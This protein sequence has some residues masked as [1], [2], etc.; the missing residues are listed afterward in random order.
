MSKKHSTLYIYK[1]NE[2][3]EKKNTDE[4]KKTKVLFFLNDLNG[5]IG[6]SK[7]LTRLE[8]RLNYISKKPIE[9]KI[10]I[11]PEKLRK[12]YL[13]QIILTTMPTLGKYLVV[14]ELPY[15]FDNKLPI[16]PI[17]LRK[18]IFGKCYNTPII[19]LPPKLEILIFGDA[20][21][22]TVSYFPSTLRILKYG[23]Y[24]NLN[25]PDN[26]P[27]TV[28]KI[29]FG[30]SFNRPIT[31]FPKMLKTI[32]FGEQFNNN[33][34]VDFPETIEK[35]IFGKTLNKKINNLDKLQNLKKIKFN[36]FIKICSPLPSKLKYIANLHITENS[37][38][39]KQS[40]TYLTYLDI[41]IENNYIGNF[42]ENLIYLRLKLLKY[43]KNILPILPPKLISLHINNYNNT[44]PELEKHQRL[45][46]LV[47]ENLQHPLQKLPYS[48]KKLYLLNISIYIFKDS[49]N[50]NKQKKNIFSNDENVKLTKFIFSMLKSHTETKYLMNLIIINTTY[51]S[52]FGRLKYI[53]TNYK[54]ALLYYTML[55]NNNKNIYIPYEIMNY[56]FINFNFTITIN[57]REFNLI[58]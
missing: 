34:L 21:N 19:T 8:K 24:Y 22:S 46:K 14:L 40:F 29:V 50:D 48:L 33:N 54:N 10:D 32:I 2:Y 11:L 35:I 1:D 44:I 37:D 18:L 17:S 15:S 5:N 39:I 49:K 9:Y 45:E 23:F 51:S 27:N 56:I 25:F 52:T 42:P 16:L 28:E 26:L 13:G 3:L 4:F 12:L 7:K 57:N 20:F 30:N 41:I 6:Y 43:T 47:I 53:Y 55:C 36:S 38:I 31:Y 58:N